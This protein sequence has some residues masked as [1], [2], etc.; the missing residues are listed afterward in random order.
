[1]E[2]VSSHGGVSPLE[3]QVE[4]RWE[5][6]RQHCGGQTANQSQAELEVLDPSGHRPGHDHN[7]R[8]QAED[9]KQPLKF[10]A[11]ILEVI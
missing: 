5:D 7:E 9:H 11:Q 3:D 4:E 8:A 1:M 10:G 2:D 6:E